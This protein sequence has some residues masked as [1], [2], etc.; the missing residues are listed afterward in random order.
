MKRQVG[1]L[2]GVSLLAVY[3]IQEQ[4]SME[5]ASAVLLGSLLLTIATTLRHRA[6]K[7]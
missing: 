5:A 7:A 4:A 6:R 3:A 1:V 2:F